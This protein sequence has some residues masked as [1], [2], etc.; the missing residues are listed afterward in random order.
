MPAFAPLLV[1]AAVSAGAHAAVISA[2]AAS[3]R[4]D[5]RTLW[6]PAEDAVA[7]PPADE[8][9]AASFWRSTGAYLSE[10]S[11]FIN[12]GLGA[13]ITAGD[14][15]D[16]QA[17]VGWSKFIVDDVEM[18]FEARLFYFDQ[19]DGD[20]LGVS[21]LF[22]LRWHLLSSAPEPEPGLDP[23]WTAFADVGIG[24]FLSS[25]NVPEGGTSFNAAPRIG[26]GFTRRLTDDG[27]RL[28]A[29]V[30]WHHI[31]NARIIGQDDN[32]S[33]DGAMVYAGLTFPF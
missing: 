4:L 25:R 21:P 3:L 28:I 24:F 17:F 22:V 33:R 19:E 10:D 14:A 15:T 27:V 32:P 13:A 26:V 29:G 5:A 9:A 20:A 11:T 1:A 6:Q 23:T 12:V 2:D 31:S 18:S 16:Y 8:A 30:H 7:P